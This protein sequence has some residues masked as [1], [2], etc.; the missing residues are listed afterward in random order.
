[1]NNK[2]NTFTIILLIV[3]LILVGIACNLAMPNFVDSLLRL[4]F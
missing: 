4:L 1:M 2:R 3:G